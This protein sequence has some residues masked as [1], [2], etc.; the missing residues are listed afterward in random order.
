ME[1]IDDQSRAPSGGH[2]DFKSRVEL[3]ALED[4]LGRSENSQLTF[5]QIT[6]HVVDRWW[7]AVYR[8]ERPIPLLPI[9][10]ARKVDSRLFEQPENLR[11]SSLGLFVR[12]GA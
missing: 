11:N 6:Y 12:V 10:I 3:D 9:S 2:S 5:S 7:L 1:S 4:Q 8:V